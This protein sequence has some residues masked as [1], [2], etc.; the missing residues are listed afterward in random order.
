MAERKI[1]VDKLKI[2]Y[3]GLFDAT[4]LYQMID[5]WLHNKGFDKREMKNNEI[6][7]PEGKYVLLELQPWKKIT[8]YA[9]LVIKVDLRMFDVKD[10]EIEKD[11]QKLKLNKGRV[12]IALWGFLDTDYENRWEEKPVYFFLRALKDKFVYKE[13]MDQYEDILIKLVEELNI[14]LKSYLNLYRYV[15]S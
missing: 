8:D 5:S 3:E 14:E 9:R 1:V 13:Y 7:K 10:V 12:V 11:H 6:V 15:S 2:T 4:N